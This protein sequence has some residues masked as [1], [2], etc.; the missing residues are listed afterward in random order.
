MVLISRRE[1]F[2]LHAVM[3]GRIDDLHR[4]DAVL[5][6]EVA[7][8]VVVEVFAERLAAGGAQIILTG[9]GHELAGGEDVVVVVDLG[10]HRSGNME[11][12]LGAVAGG[13][14]EV[15]MPAD[16]H[17]LGLVAHVVRHDAGVHGVGG[18]GDGEVEVGLREPVA[19]E[20]AGMNHAGDLLAAGDGLFRDV[21]G[22]GL[23]DEAVHGVALGAGQLADVVGGQRDGVA[24]PLGGEGLA[25]GG[26]LAA[27]AVG[28]GNE[29]RRAQPIAEIA[30]GV[31][32]LV[33]HLLGACESG[34]ASTS[35]FPLPGKLAVIWSSSMPRPGMTV[36]LVNSGLVLLAAVRVRV[37]IF[38][39]PIS[40]A[41]W[42]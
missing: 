31:V 26:E 3:R 10:Q 25:V 24:L 28:I 42:A 16:G 29:E 6:V 9:D 38:W 11:A 14:V 19:A 34:E 18:E 8:V 5:P 27:N 32:V 21:V 15:G 23:E 13:Q 12:H 30:V 1:A 35:T 36:T 7:P 39:P 2:D 37:T 17:G 4:D 22:L 40:G 33:E 20:V 41:A